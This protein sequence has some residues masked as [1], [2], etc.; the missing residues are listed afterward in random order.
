MSAA[1]W[2]LEFPLSTCPAPA[3]MLPL[4]Q[5]PRSPQCPCYTEASR[6]GGGELR[7]EVKQGRVPWPT[8]PPPQSRHVLICNMEIIP[9]PP[10]PSCWSPKVVLW[11]AWWGLHSC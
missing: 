3:A 9:P 7:Q 11:S 8:S 1:L 6:V 10:T 2:M 4:R 5:D